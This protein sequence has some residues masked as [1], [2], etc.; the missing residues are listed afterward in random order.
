MKHPFQNEYFSR[1][2]GL[3]SEEQQERL[4]NSSVL[5]A[6]VGADGGLLAERLVRFGIG[7][8]ILA[9][10]EKFEAA[11]INRQFAA[12][13]KNFGRNKAECVANELIQINPALKIEVLNDGL[14]SGNIG[15]MV[16]AA[17]VVADEIEYSLPAISVMLHREARTQNKFVFM[18]ANVGWGASIFC[19]S[20]SGKTFEEEFEYN[21][22]NTSINPL[23]Y[24]KEAP[25]YLGEEMLASVVSG[26]APVPALSSSVS[27]VAA[28]MANEIILFILGKRKPLIVPQFLSIDL[29]DLTL[30][31]I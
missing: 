15:K 18:G 26:S 20:P 19:F 12:Y 29:F 10:P 4:S 5:V 2:S 21:E 1:N 6:G 27:L 3:I 25:S 22:E 28:C 17:D 16:Y 14:H 31:K 13:Q 30:S 9:D 23:R 11:N 8:I 24:L 7:K